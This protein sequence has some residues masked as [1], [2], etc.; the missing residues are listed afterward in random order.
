MSDL[1]I[2]L[3][4]FNNYPVLVLNL[5]NNQKFKHSVLTYQVKKGTQFQ[6]NIIFSWFFGKFYFSGDGHISFNFKLGN[7]KNVMDYF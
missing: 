7:S 6:N 2:S 4:F 3:N 1:K 5:K